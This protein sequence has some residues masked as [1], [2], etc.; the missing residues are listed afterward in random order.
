[1]P[2]I[3][4]FLFVGNGDELLLTNGTATPRTLVANINAGAS[5]RYIGSKAEDL[6]GLPFGAASAFHMCCRPGI[7]EVA[8]SSL[9]SAV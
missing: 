8:V 3:P 7:A 1:M 5:L 2:L 4:S 9:R 6:D